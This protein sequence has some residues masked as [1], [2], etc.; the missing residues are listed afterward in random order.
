MILNY[1]SPNYVPTI[2]VCFY[3]FINKYNL[4]IKRKWE[5]TECYR[6]NYVNVLFWNI[7]I[8]LVDMMLIGDN[9]LWNHF[10]SFIICRVYW[11]WF[12]GSLLKSDCS[13]YRKT[14]P[15]LNKNK[16]KVGSILA[17]GIYLGHPVRLHLYIPTKAK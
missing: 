14:F 6:H 5:L 1:N 4:L 3:F 10:V 15:I 8:I 9:K 12:Y 7:I 13:W 16:Q 17:L 2:Y 11:L